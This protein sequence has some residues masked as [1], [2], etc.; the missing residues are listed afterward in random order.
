V[1][2]YAHREG[3]RFYLLS[4]HLA[5][6]AAGAAV[7]LSVH[8]RR[9]ELMAAALLAGWAHDFGKYS[10]FFQRYLR[11]GRGGPE[12]QHAF[13]S[14]LW[15]AHLAEQF[16]ISPVHSLA[17][18]ISICRHHRS[19]AD[20]EELLLPPRELAGPSWD[21]LEPAQSER[22][23]IT[24]RQIDA[25]RKETEAAA[26]T[27]SLRMAARHTSRLLQQKDKLAPAWLDAD[28]S[29]LL[30][31]FF[32]NWIQSY[33]RL[34]RYRRRQIRTG[35]GKNLQDYFDLLAL[36]SAV[37]D[38][39]KIH[40]ARLKDT[41]RATLP[42]QPVKTYR[43]KQFDPPRTA[44][45]QLREELY[46]T[47]CRT[48][49]EAPPS[50]KLFT[51]TAP[52]GSGKT[53]AGLAAAFI[54][55]QK[56][57][58]SGADTPRIIYALPFTSIVDQTF[59][60]VETVLRAGSKAAK[61]SAP[62]PSTWLLK[63]HHLAETAYRRPGKKDEEPLSLDQVL[64]LIESWQS[65]IIITTFVQLLHTLIGSE[66]RMLKKFHRLQN[67][68]LILDEVQNIPVEYWPLVENVLREACRHLGTRV[69]LM[70]ATRP[71]WFGEG[72]AL[73]LAGPEPQIRQRFAT[74][75][76][77]NITASPEPFTV[78]ELA[79]TFQKSYRVGC[80]Y[81]VILNTIKSSITFY[82]LLKEK[83]GKQADALY[84]LST[85]ITPIER[86]RRLQQLRELLERGGKPVLVSTQV[87]E[88]GV[89]LDF[90]EVWRDLGPVDAVVQAAGRCNRHFARDCGHVRV[91][92]LVDRTERGTTTL[93]QYV[94]GKIHT[95]AAKKMFEQEL[96]FQERDFYDAIAGY[97]E[98]VRQSKSVTASKTLLEAMQ[99]WRFSRRDRDSEMLGVAN[100]A[101]IE[102]RPHYV[103]VFV[104]LDDNA[105]E[106]WQLY[107]STVV[108]EKDFWKRRQ[109]F[110]ALKRN[111]SAY[112]LSVPAQLV[113]GRLD[114]ATNPLYIPKD[115][116]G[117]FYD[118]ET[119]FKRINDEMVLI[120]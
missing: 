34:Y 32:N 69:L 25:L 95:H 43:D 72:E 28:W 18:F 38:A 49:E 86:A 96:L 80:S 79:D 106:T 29:G 66:N 111:F 47:V 53:L 11:S 59:N 105:A 71:E 1:P 74:L 62:L 64:L 33:G 27:R 84:Y 26:V 8:P 2:Y 30:Q 81:L 4:A 5:E 15:A 16:E 108:N 22:L 120:F 82:H 92:H 101:L 112:V 118:T 12:K 70:T 51:I 3:K 83:L 46:T 117:E 7:R 31:V 39:D 102:D 110:L 6:T 13:I 75:D 14:A 10:P 100:F 73:E 19:L 21:R 17:L 52:T 55:R 57:A 45:D 78:E 9:D 97:F 61:N 41:E 65:E 50:Q 89:D 88:A 76:R 60:T 119:G 90:D 42:L 24:R 48:M 116:L 20:P 109:A 114:P 115:I 94:Y 93:A 77:V 67:A 58:G 99:F 107:Q 54:L 113:V 35:S 103:N 104:E 36:F 40:A 56:L 87:V 68:V 23:Q 63:H 91:W 44:V 85:N 98:T 37:I